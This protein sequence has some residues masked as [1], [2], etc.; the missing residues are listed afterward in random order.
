MTPLLAPAST[1]ARP[2]SVRPCSTDP[3][4]PRR[5]SANPGPP[6]E[7]HPAQRRS[8][9][10]AAARAARTVTHPVLSPSTHTLA[11]R[12][13]ATGLRSWTAIRPPIHTRS[14]ASGTP[15]TPTPSPLSS[16]TSVSYP[17]PPHRH[18]FLLRHPNTLSHP[19]T[20]SHTPLSLMR[21]WPA[22]PA[23]TLGGRQEARF[24]C[25]WVGSP[26]PFRPSEPH[27]LR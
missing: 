24:R 12:T 18:R 4:L 23:V 22:V 15:D 11:S 17:H 10:L 5:H 6:R 16:L 7:P 27:Y 26:P 8:L 1:G 2:M 19:P 9:T 3:P 14:L 20:Y 13:H 21:P 25:S